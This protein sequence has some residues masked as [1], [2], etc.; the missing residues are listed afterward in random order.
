MANSSIFDKLEN[1][2]VLTIGQIN[3][4]L[5]ES[6]KV[7]KIDEDSLLYLKAIK[8]LEAEEVQATKEINHMHK[9]ELQRINSEF[10]MNDYERRF[11]ITQEEVLS[12]LIGE[13]LT[14]I[15]YHRQL[16]EQKVTY[17]I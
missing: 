6:R 13:D 8:I 4:I 10:L 14:P 17:T 9:K 2:T 15:E 7:M 12:A 16:R 11:N 3:K 1:E 5:D